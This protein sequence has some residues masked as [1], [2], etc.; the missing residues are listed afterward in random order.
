MVLEVCSCHCYLKN[1]GPQAEAWGHTCHPTL[2]WTKSPCF[3]PLEY[4][5]GVGPLT[6]A[7][8]NNINFEENKA[9]TCMS[10]SFQK[11][12]GSYIFACRGK[13]ITFEAISNDMILT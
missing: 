6:E 3:K 10:S 2:S 4:D 9:G 12:S 11:F 5:S 1:P 7:T 8:D 13:L